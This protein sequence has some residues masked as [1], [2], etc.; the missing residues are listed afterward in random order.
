ML[1]K[2]ISNNIFTPLKWHHA[3]DFTCQIKK[4]HLI[5]TLS[6]QSIILSIVLLSLYKY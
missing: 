6:A 4:K 3:Y 1:F 5:L 2:Q